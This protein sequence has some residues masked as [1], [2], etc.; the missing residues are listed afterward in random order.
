MC[1]Y[2]EEIQFLKGKAYVAETVV[3]LIFT[4]ETCVTAI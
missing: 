2:L 1:I 3:A 4:F